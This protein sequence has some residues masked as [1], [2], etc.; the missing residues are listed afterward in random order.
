ML[1]FESDYTNGCH[2]EILK[3]LVSTNSE[4]V[5]GYGNDKFC[6]SAETKIL[7]ACGCKNGHVEFITGGTQT[8]Q[9]AIDA[10]TGLGDGIIAAR[11]GHINCHEAGAI[12]YTGHKVIELPQYQGKL[13]ASDVSEYLDIFYKDENNKAMVRPAMVYISHPTEYGTLYTLSELQE[14]H[15]ICS[16]YNIP[17]F[18]DG[19]RLGYGLASSSADVTL[20]DIA[21]LTDLFYIG[22]TKVGALCGEALVFTHENCPE[23]FF[24]YKK[25]HGA[26][27]AK[28]RLLGVQFDTLFTNDLYMKISRNAIETAHRLVDVLKKHGI[29]FFLETSTNQQF[30]ILENTVMKKLSSKV[31]FGFWETV[32][33]EHTAVRFATSWAT[34][35]SQ[36]DELDRILSENL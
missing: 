31:G 1:T 11:T 5:S 17:L 8:N 36:L 24:S 29:E 19:A 20:K 26:L 12:E 6:K 7:E 2:E 27:L 35:D 18:L 34:T 9:L 33:S 23:R 10:M 21:R 15:N 28:G 4:L 13:K 30:V 32:D 16:S 25:M 22:G 3:A 14:L